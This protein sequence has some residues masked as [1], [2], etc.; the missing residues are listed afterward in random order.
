MA[1]K[2]INVKIDI[3][4]NLILLSFKFP[5]NREILAMNSIKTINR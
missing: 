1:N 4:P 3:V 5:M 2:I